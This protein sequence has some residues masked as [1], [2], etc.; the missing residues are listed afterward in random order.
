MGL[1]TKRDTCY[2]CGLEGHWSRICRTLKHFVHLYQESLLERIHGD[3]CGPIHPSCRP[4]RYCMVLIDASTRWS[5]VSLLSKRNIDFA[6]LLIQ[7][8]RLKAQFPDYSIKTIRLDNASEFTSKSFHDYCMAVGIQVEHPVAH[9]HTQNGLT[10]S[11]I[12]RLQIIA[13]PM[14]LRTKLPK[15]T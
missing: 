14:L 15:S 11:L 7:V 12:K 2:R 4:F 6:R 10:E 8:F 1:E 13:R 9:I 5:Y 3:I